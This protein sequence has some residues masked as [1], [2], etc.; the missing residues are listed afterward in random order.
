MINVLF[1]HPNFPGQFKHILPALRSHGGYRL[2]YICRQRHIKDRAGIQI[3]QYEYTKP[4]RT[5]GHRY[6]H[7]T[8]EAIRETQKVCVEANALIH[9]GFVPDIIV[10][11][12]GWGGLL[13][14]KDMFPAAKVIGYCELYF[15]PEFDFSEPGETVS[16]DRKAQ[17]RCRNMHTLMQMENMDIGVT[18][19]KWQLDSHPPIYHDKLNVI[20]EG[21]DT[22][23]CK[24]DE[25]ARFPIKEKGL[26]LTKSD[27]VITYVSRGFEPAR[28]FFQY[29]ASLE[30]LCKSLPHAHFVM[31]GGE[32]SFYSG[33]AGEKSF[34]E[35]GLEKYDI[36]HNRVHFTGRLTHE[37][38]RK[39]LQISSAHVY[40]TKPLFL[41]WS[42]VEAMSMAAPIVASDQQLVREFI[43]HEEQGL[44]VNEDNPVE[45]ANAVSR[46]VANPELSRRLGNNARKVMVKNYD[47]SQTVKDWM[48]IIESLS[49]EN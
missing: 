1:I 19:T 5:P 25:S 20:H 24:P 16:N 44:L 30:I 33:D 14:M 8:Q 23:L 6:L 10:G 46:L 7:H 26:M 27:T 13:F 47:I 38:F 41:S 48:K 35:I 18:P 3:R 12:N 32:K 4:D 21:V 36:D 39:V 31:V 37:G 45:I 42:A 43:T 15:R 9:E 40:L 49:P 17:L 11:H 34:K 29:L 28:G 22:D 2:A